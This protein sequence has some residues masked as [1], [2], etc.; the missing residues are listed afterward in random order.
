MAWLWIGGHTGAVPNGSTCW[1]DVEISSAPKGYVCG[2]FN[3]HLIC[4]E[5]GLR[6]RCTFDTHWDRSKAK[7]GTVKP[8]RGISHFSSSSF[9][10]RTRERFRPNQF[11]EVSP[12]PPLRAEL[13]RKQTE[14]S[15]GSPSVFPASL[16]PKDSLPRVLAS[17]R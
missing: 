6:A 14:T 4:Q 2:K 5:R 15:W 16:V 13:G 7:L 3:V 9:L 10:R 8:R 12:G 17:T 11:L 1:A